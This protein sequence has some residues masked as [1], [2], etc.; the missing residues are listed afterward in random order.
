M[1]RLDRTASTRSRIDFDPHDE[2][3]DLSKVVSKMSLC[4]PPFL[5]SE[6]L[7]SRFSQSIFIKSTTLI[8]MVQF[9]LRSSLKV[10]R[11]E[12][13][14]H[15]RIQAERGS[16]WLPLLVQKCWSFAITTKPTCTCYI[17][18]QQSSFNLCSILLCVSSGWFSAMAD[19]KGSKEQRSPH[20]KRSF[21]SLL[22]VLRPKRQK[23]TVSGEKK[24][25][26]LPGPFNVGIKIVDLLDWHHSFGFR[27]SGRFSESFQV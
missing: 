13:N 6:F 20:P 27:R 26:I 5:V 18:C 3:I 10:S 11:N 15:E 8:A 12:G 17:N 16:W 9:T 21:Q 19:A 7:A 14:R 2:P 22:V 1:G 4:L 23:G 24:V 25:R